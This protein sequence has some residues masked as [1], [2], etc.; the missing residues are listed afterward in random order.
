KGVVV[1]E[2]NGEL[3]IDLHIKVLF[4]LNIAAIVQS[5]TNKVRYVVEEA[6]N[7]KVYKINVSVDDIVAE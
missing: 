2:H 5:I 4:G 1:S 3:I 7:L 6:T